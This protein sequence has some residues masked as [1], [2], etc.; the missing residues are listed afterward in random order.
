MNDF[1]SRINVNTHLN[2][3]DWLVFACACLICVV[4]IRYGHNKKQ[5]LTSTTTTDNTSVV[6]Y[7]LMGRQLTLP[8]FVATLVATWYG[9]IFGV[10]QIAFEQGVYNLFTQGI[11]W[12]ITYIIF[13]FF[14]A[15]KIRSYSAI[16]L[17]ELVEKIYGKKSAKLTAIFI[18][19]KTLPITYAISIGLFLQCIMPLS[20]LEA[21][22]IGVGLIAVYA[23]SGGL[24][25]VVYSDVAL[26]IIMCMGVLCV[27][28]FSILNFGGWGFLQAN[29]PSSYFKPCGTNSIATTLVW[30]FIACSSTFISPAFYQR[31]L[32]AANDKIAVHGILVST[33]IWFVFDLC[34]T[35]SAMYAK[36]VIPNADS[37]HAYITYGIQLLPNGFKGLLLASIAAAIIATLDSFLFI[38]SN[39]LFYDLKLFDKFNTKLRHMSAIIITALL[40]IL[41]S[42][43]FEGRIENA[44]LVIKSYFAACLLLPILCGY[45]FPRLASDTLFV[46]SCVIS[47]IC[48]TLWQTKYFAHYKNIDSFYIGCLATFIVYFAFYLTLETR[49]TTLI[50]RIRRMI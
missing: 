42:L 18:F 45:I 46:T 8:L 15:K 5:I 6:E 2:L 48:V 16:T 23:L 3:L 44:W 29:L 47:S 34:T 11:F 49:I 50:D 9:G 17:P 24:R 22:C 28:F 36:A 20:L 41:A 35:F 27:M 31:C 32:A 10:T 21:T 7:L 25:T 30:F 26:F 1:A 40:T 39:T 19:F 43:Y 38:A 33:A 37:L 14:L 4:L 12:Y 13:A